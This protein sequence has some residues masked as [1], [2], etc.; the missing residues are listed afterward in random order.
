M[1]NTCFV[2]MTVYNGAA[3]LRECLESVLA[4]E[5]TEIHFSIVD[6]G[7]SDDSGKILREYAK[8]YPDRILISESERNEGIGTALAKAWKQYTGEA[9]FAMIGQDDIWEKGF[10]VS[11]IM[12]LQQNNALVSFAQVIPINEA[13]QR[14]TPS[15]CSFFQHDYLD[16]SD[17][18]A[19]LLRL[20]EGNFLCAPSAVV[21]L[22]A[23]KEPD[24]FPLLFGI[25]N[26]CLQDYEL[27]LNLCLQGCFLYNRNSYVKYRM[28]GTSASQPRSRW[29]QRKLEYYQALDRSL[30]SKYFWD[31]ILHTKGPSECFADV[32]DV[33]WSKAEYTNPN[34][35]LTIKLCEEALSYGLDTS[36]IRERLASAYQDFGLL[37]KAK[38]T[39]GYLPHKIP[40]SFVSAAADQD[41]RTV[42]LRTGL[43]DFKSP[44][45]AN[46]IRLGRAVRGEVP[47]KADI[48]LV[49]DDCL[50]TSNNCLMLKQNE[51]D[52]DHIL[53]FIEDSRAV[54]RN[55]ILD[56][57]PL[58]NSF[59]A[60]QKELERNGAA[61]DS[62]LYKM[63]R[64]L[65]DK[66]R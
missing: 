23:L 27:W 7:S 64:A 34:R 28:H 43:F 16:T 54:F 53:P 8:R 18:Q 35:L 26:D 10:L 42:F 59:E 38:K 12:S 30:T 19:V 55:G 14:I 3:T 2:C 61:L 11:Q 33:V 60:Y 1:H 32:V 31:Y 46:T 17:Q 49:D 41:L 62:R 24:V 56:V 13:G 22:C 5:N 45:S 44:G 48:V 6:D 25:H 66:L 4:Q 29:C 65:L 36:R 15:K 39:V 63:C 58:D 52:A 40:A 21:R 9:Y 47:E 37:T 51:L 20:I 50:Q 57:Y